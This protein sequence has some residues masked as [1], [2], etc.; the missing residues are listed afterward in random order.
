MIPYFSMVIMIN[1][2]E[3]K[4]ITKDLSL[5]EL[6]DDGL[7][8]KRTFNLLTRVQSNDTGWP[9]KLSEIYK[10]PSDTFW[11]IH[12]FGKKCMD[13][14]KNIQN[15]IELQDSVVERMIQNLALEYVNK[16]KPWRSL[17]EEGIAYSAFISGYKELL[18]K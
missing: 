4:I 14:I 2:K 10:I 15:N 3:M 11:M 13:E 7:L 16:F 9:S 18:N 1:R 5:K 17:T 6:L 12:G 8:S